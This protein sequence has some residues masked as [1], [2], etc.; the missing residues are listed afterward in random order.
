MGCGSS[1][2]AVNQSDPQVNGKG[3]YQQLAI[4]EKYTFGKKLGSGSFASCAVGTNKETGEKFAIKTLLKSHENYDRELLDHE[5]RIMIAV[6][7][8]RCIKLVEVFEDKKAVHLVEELAVGGELFD[9]IIL[10]GIAH[11][12]SVGA[13]HRDLKPENL[14]MVSDNPSKP[15][16]M[17]L[18]IADFGL[19]SLRPVMGEQSMNTVCGTPDYLAPEVVMIASQGRGTR[20]KYD[21]KVDV[22]A[23]GVILYTML[24]GYPPFYSENLAELLSLIQK[25]EVKFPKDPWKN[26]SKETRQYVSLLLTV[27]QKKR[28]TSMECL[29]HSLMD[30]IES[31]Q[32]CGDVSEPDERLVAFLAVQVSPC[33][34]PFT[35]VCSHL[36]VSNMIN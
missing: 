11:M 6:A 20:V 36:K 31:R 9:R 4:T 29:K 8:P 16:Y 21:A 10:E 30:N 23:T 35:E 1:S 32:T 27:D 25:G 13:C 19:S 17:H 3:N 12:H 14:L 5:V 7:H 26:V 28:P 24:A 22:W 2:Q 34:P 18:K 33:P 15:E